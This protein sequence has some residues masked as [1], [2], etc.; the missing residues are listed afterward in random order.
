[1]IGTFHIAVK[2]E[3]LF[4]N[5]CAHSDRSNRHFDTLRMVGISDRQMKGV[6]HRLHSFQ[7]DAFIRAGI[8]GR[9]VQ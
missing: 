3:M 5:G 7:I 6:A 4:D 1:M 9:A 8:F 2:R